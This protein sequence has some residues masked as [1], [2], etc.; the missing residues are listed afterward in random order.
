MKRINIIIIIVLAFTFN[1]SVL[2]ASGANISNSVGVEKFVENFN[3]YSISYENIYKI[4]EV[5]K[6]GTL[7]EGT[8]YDCFI[9]D[10]V[11]QKGNI[12]IGAVSS[13]S[14]YLHDICIIVGIHA[15]SNYRAAIY[16]AAI[17]VQA[18]MDMDGN[19]QEIILKNIEAFAKKKYGKQDGVE[20][21]WRS[22][23]GREYYVKCYNDSDTGAFVVYIR[24]HDN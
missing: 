20:K 1:V 9:E 14:G 6:S 24:C 22:N 16:I 11:S 15:K 5:R 4:H 21:I 23:N 18:T 17:A 8:Y 2:E 19:D 7:S 13:P 10:D 3:K 12:L